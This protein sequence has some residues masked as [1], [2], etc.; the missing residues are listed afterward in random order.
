VIAVLFPLR[1]Q[2]LKNKI[3]KKNFHAFLGLCFKFSLL[4]LLFSDFHLVVFYVLDS[5]AVLIHTC[6]RELSPAH[7]VCPWRHNA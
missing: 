6:K 2:I 4:I 7:L 5:V 3:K 1:I